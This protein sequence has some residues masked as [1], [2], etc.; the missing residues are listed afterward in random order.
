MDKK[1]RF[2]VAFVTRWPLLILIVA[3]LTLVQSAR[4]QTSSTI[5]GTVTDKQGLAVT[6]AE[7]RAEGSTAAASRTVVTD[8]SGAYQIAG[9]PAG[10]YKLTITPGV[11][12]RGSLRGWN[13]HSI[14]P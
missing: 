7:I 9:L 3:L 8:A 6:G 11:L 2:D 14:A 10:V 13:S 12:V 1:L 4:A 5:E